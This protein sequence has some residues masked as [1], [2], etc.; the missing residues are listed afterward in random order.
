MLDFAVLAQECAPAVHPDTMRRI[1]HVESSFNPYAI[2]V[3]G[4]RLQRQPTT[5]AEALA[6]A[7]ALEA[8]RHDYS[9][10]LAQVNRRNFSRYGLTLE[11]AFDP[12]VNLRAGARILAECYGWARTSRDEQTALRA[13]ASC[14]YSGNFTT[15]YA[16]GYVQRIVDAEASARAIPIVPALRREAGAQPAPH[17]LRVIESREKRTTIRNT[18]TPSASRPTSPA[19]N[20]SPASNTRSAL[21]F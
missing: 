13:A 10:G 12:C 1:V 21:L 17:P 9:V 4:G 16:H 19:A 11:T 18:E 7:R 6:T 3:V 8:S 15:G 20:A 14:Y 2:G 5:L